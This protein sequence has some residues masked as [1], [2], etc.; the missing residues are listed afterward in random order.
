MNGSL[1]G[2]LVSERLFEWLEY[3]G[4]TTAEVAEKQGMSR[5]TVSNVLNGKIERPHL[6]TARKIARHFGVT[7]EEFL[8][9]IPEDPKVRARN[10]AIAEW[11]RALPKEEH[12]SLAAGLYPQWTMHEASTA[13]GIIEARQKVQEAGFETEEVLDFL[14]RNYEF[15]AEWL[16]RSAEEVRNAREAVVVHLDLQRL[17]R[18][19]GLITTEELGQRIEEFEVA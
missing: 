10:D 14:L 12:L 16:K 1:D 2:S 3:S 17:A 18:Q 8:A 15:T 4:A 13:R 11:L 19:R 9:G 6:N 5:T 7:V